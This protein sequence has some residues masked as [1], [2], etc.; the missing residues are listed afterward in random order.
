[1]LKKILSWPKKGWLWLTK[2]KTALVLL[3][4]LALAAIPGALLPQRSLN[5][6]KVAEYIDANG[7]TAEVFDK[8]Q[9]FDVFSSTWFVAIYVLL[10]ISLVGCILPR[11]IDHYKALRSSPP[12]APKR[13]DRMPY[14]YSGTVDE[15][16]EDVQKSLR[17]EFKGW[18]VNEVDK[19][20][21][22]AGAWSMSR[23]RA[24]ARLRT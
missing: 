7:K 15:S 8:L 17:E 22:R 16:V 1:M 2:M 14:H 24:T 23:R 4:L 10:F 11:S 5:E 3:F 20:D 9:L 6:G 13:L 19:D 12:P 18:N 21:D